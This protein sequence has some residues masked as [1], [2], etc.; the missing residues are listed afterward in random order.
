MLETEE[1]YS[2]FSRCQNLGNKGK[3]TRWVGLCCSD[4]P[5]NLGTQADVNMHI[6]LF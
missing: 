2:V 4:A 1:Q 6:I 5:D 3:F